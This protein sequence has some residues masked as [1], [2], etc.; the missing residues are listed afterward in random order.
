MEIKVVRSKKRKKTV[1]AR[2]VDG[3]FVVQAPADM[4][5]QDLQP[6]I[7]NLQQR[8]QKKQVKAELD[9]QALHRRAQELNREYF[10]GKL[11][12]K[13]IKWVTNQNSRFGSC[14]PA[15]GTI[16]LSHR[17]AAMPAFVRDY[18]LIHEMAH[19]LEANHGP[20]FWKLVNRYPKTERA[21]GYLMAVGLEEIED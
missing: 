14:T 5:D 6:I 11:K 13:S 15:K 1:S 18:V 10:G 4:N 19:L 7:E 21:R 16:R 12:W 2:E 8:W 17:L 3:V 20:Q 9:D